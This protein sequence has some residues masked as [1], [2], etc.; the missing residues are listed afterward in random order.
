MGRIKILRKKFR[1]LTLFIRVIVVS[2]VRVNCQKKSI[3]LRSRRNPNGNISRLSNISRFRENAQ[4]SL[5]GKQ[6][7]AIQNMHIATDRESEHKHLLELA[8]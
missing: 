3:V 4:N 1:I 5:M 7:H 8:A 6:L 2:L